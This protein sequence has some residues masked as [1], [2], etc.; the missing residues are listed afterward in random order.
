VRPERLAGI[1]VGTTRQVGGVRP[2][3]DEDASLGCNH[4]DPGDQGGAIDPGQAW[5]D[6]DDVRSGF[7]SE[8]DGAIGGSRGPDDD[9]PLADPKQAGKALA[10]AVVRVDDEYAKG[11]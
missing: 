10:D 3:E 5:I 11:R 9:A 2:V 6:D 1:G 7:G 8:A 4:S